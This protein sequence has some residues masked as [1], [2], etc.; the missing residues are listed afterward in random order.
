MITLSADVFGNPYLPGS[1][2]QVPKRLYEDVHAH[3]SLKTEMDAVKKRFK[4]AE[5]QLAATAKEFRGIFD[6]TRDGLHSVYHCAGV[7]VMIDRTEKVKTEKHTAPT[8]KKP[9][10]KEGEAGEKKATVKKGA[11][12]KPATGKDIY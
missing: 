2:I 8:P 11:G 10:K 7:D 3:E 1:E 5:A 4:K 12:K 6:T 9:S